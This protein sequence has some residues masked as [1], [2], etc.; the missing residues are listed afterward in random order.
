M[1]KPAGPYKNGVIVLEVNGGADSK[2][3]LGYL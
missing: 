1:K 2:D 3:M